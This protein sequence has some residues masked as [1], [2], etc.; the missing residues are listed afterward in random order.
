MRIL[1][2][3]PLLLLCAPI[4]EAKKKAKPA[5]APPPA[6]PIPAELQN[7]VCTITGDTLGGTGFIATFK[8]KT[9]LATNQHVIFGQKSL[10]IRNSQGHDFKPTGGLVAAE[11]D[12]ALLFL[13]DPLPEGI[14]PFILSENING[15][16]KEGD[17]ITIVGNSDAAGTL[18]TTGGHVK[19]FGPVRL[20]HDAAVIGGTSGGPVYHHASGQVIALN[21]EGQVMKLGREI[22]QVSASQGGTA[23]KDGTLRLW[24]HRADTEKS[25]ITLDWKSVNSVEEQLTKIGVAIRDAKL[26]LEVGLYANVED[27]FLRKKLNESIE[28]FKSSTGSDMDAYGVFIKAVDSARGSMEFKAKQVEPQI[29]T[30][31][32]RDTFA[33]MKAVVTSYA[34]GLELLKEDISLTRA[35]YAGKYKMPEKIRVL[36]YPSG[37]VRVEKK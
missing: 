13:G 31:L 28:K 33:G 11:A 2:L 7:S 16:A 21:T 3:L 24:G 25:W 35:M 32:H 4:A 10:R 12:I 26:L 14:K 17:E 22:D 18:T 34:R 29:K 27:E 36:V 9:V 30:Y 23:V 8:G 15:L 37:A 5:P 20:E 6:K 1:A 19:F